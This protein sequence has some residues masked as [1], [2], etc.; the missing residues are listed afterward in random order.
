[1]VVRAIQESDL[2]LNPNVDGTI[3]GRGTWHSESIATGVHHVIVSLNA[4]QACASAQDAKDVRVAESGT[5]TVQLAPR[6]CGMFSLDAAPVGG[7]FVLSSGTHEV[8]SG[9]VPLTAPVLVPEGTYALRVSA[10]Y[11][12]DYSGTVSISTGATDH[13]RVRLICQ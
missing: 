12:A 3:V 7:R 11:C 2:G 1:S 8:A 10:K 13:E 5:T 6:R 9:V 4:P